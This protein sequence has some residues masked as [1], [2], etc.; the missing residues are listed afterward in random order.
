MVNA[1]GLTGI[2]DWE[3]AAWGDP[4]EDIGWLCARCWRFGGPGEVG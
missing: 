1:T 4:H 3:F 2:L